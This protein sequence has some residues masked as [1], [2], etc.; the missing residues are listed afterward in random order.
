MKLT[1]DFFEGTASNVANCKGI[2]RQN[3]LFAIVLEFMEEVTA[4]TI[5]TM[6]HHDT[7]GNNDDQTG[8]MVG[9]ACFRLTHH[10]TRIC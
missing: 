9:G 10:Q 4:T 2:L 1:G 3:V 6:S 8:H 7:S 5:L